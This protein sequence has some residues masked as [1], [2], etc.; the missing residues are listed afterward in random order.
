MPEHVSALLRQLPQA[1]RAT[2]IACY[3]QGFAL[4]QAGSAQHG[5]HID[6][7]EVAA[8]WQGGCILRAAL[9]ERIAAGYRLA[10]G[11]ANLMLA[12]AIA[13]AMAAGRAHWR[14]GVA[15]AA[16]GRGPAPALASALP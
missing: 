11:L 3:A 6:P 14:A 7:A 4:I 10:P 16:L 9:L 15:A 8:V 13:R 2:T 12:P 1:L 5:W